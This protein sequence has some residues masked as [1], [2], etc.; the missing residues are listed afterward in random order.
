MDDFI[1][2]TQCEELN[3]EESYIWAKY[4]Y[5]VEDKSPSTKILG[6]PAKEDI[7]HDYDEGGKL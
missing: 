4:E 1:V 6:V 2:G 5:I 7:S 3:E